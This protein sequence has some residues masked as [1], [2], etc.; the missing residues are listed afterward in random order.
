ME[1]VLS[2]LLSL[3][4]RKTAPFDKDEAFDVLIELKAMARFN[5]H[6]AKLPYFQAVFQALKDKTSAS[7]GRF[8]KYLAALLGDKH[9]ERVLDVMA[10]VDKS[11]QRSAPALRRPLQTPAPNQGYRG[12]FSSVQYFYCQIYS[13]TQVL[14]NSS[15]LTVQART[16]NLH[17]E[18]EL[19]FSPRMRIMC[20][21]S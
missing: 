19:V 12:S 13:L 18:A 2:K 7:P 17:Y 9:Q 15:S 21:W 4:L 1:D 3:L 20:M 6:H 16:L 11:V 8:K 14:Q 5:T 10:K